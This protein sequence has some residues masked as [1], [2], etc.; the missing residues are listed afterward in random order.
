[1]EILVQKHFNITNKRIRFF[2][3]SSWKDL[4]K[5]AIRS[6]ALKF[7][8]YLSLCGR[9]VVASLIFALYTVTHMQ[10]GEQRRNM[11]KEVAIRAR[12][13]HPT[14]KSKPT[15]IYWSEPC[16]DKPVYLERREKA[17]ILI[18]TG[19]WSSDLITRLSN[20]ARFS[21]FEIHLSFWGM[22]VNGGII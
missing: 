20:I 8:R 6:D 12:D 22:F 21:A 13:S 11:E 3:Y 18:T 1:M 4:W 10:Y 5:L 15:R 7:V 19:N 2:S 9:R 16:T 17:G 14:I